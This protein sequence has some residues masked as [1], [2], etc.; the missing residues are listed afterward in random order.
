[1][2]SMLTIFSLWLEQYPSFLLAAD[3]VE[4][5]VGEAE[6]DVALPAVFGESLSLDSSALS[7]DEAW[8]RKFCIH[9]DQ[10]RTEQRARSSLRSA[11][12]MLRNHLADQVLPTGGKRSNPSAMPKVPNAYPVLR[13]MAEMRGFYPLG[14]SL[15]SRFKDFQPLKKNLVYLEDI[16]A[17]QERAQLIGVFISRLLDEEGATSSANVGVTVDPAST[18]TVKAGGTGENRRSTRQLVEVD[19]LVPKTTGPSTPAQF[20]DKPSGKR[21]HQREKGEETKDNSKLNGSGGKG[22]QPE[23]D[24]AEKKRAKHS[25]RDLTRVPVSS[26]AA[27][28]ESAEVAIT[29]LRDFPVL[30]TLPSK[31]QKSSSSI[32]GN[33][34]SAA[35]TPSR[36]DGKSVVTNQEFQVGSNSLSQPHLPGLWEYDLEGDAEDNS[37]EQLNQ[38]IEEMASDYRLSTHNSQDH[39]GTL[40]GLTPSTSNHRVALDPENENSFAIR[41]GKDTANEVNDEDD[42]LDDVVFRPAFP[43]ESGASSTS[44]APQLEL[45]SSKSN[46]SSSHHLRLSE[47]GSLSAPRSSTQDIFAALGVSAGDNTLGNQDSLNSFAKDSTTGGNTYSKS[48]DI[49]AQ[50]GIDNFSG[51][52]QRA[53]VIIVYA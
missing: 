7:S 43:R 32:D 27:T 22:S 18:A 23:R 26:T 10:G 17:Y 36:S 46:N 16:A 29:D 14:D 41:D 2:L 5:E 49:W 9:K 44:P 52:S 4:P 28:L 53:P 31:V 6:E 47:R 1:M 21:D 48:N 20:T 24:S 33:T 42:E 50:F 11:M 12:L 3:E 38:S 25:G 45:S 39:L 40:L 8:K 51:N 15:E 30:P 37:F 19:K 34:A 13:E 35:V